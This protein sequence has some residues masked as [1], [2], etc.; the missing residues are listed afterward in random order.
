MAYAVPNSEAQ[1]F[2]NTG[3]SP[4]HENTLYFSSTSNKDSYFDGLTKYSVSSVTYQR[5]HRGF[6]RIELPV[7]SLIRCDYMRFKNNSF[8]N[9]WFY[10]FITQVNYINNNTTEI[11]YEL[12]PL[13][14]WMGAF[15]LK[16]CFV[17]RQHTHNDG[18][19][20]NICDEGL[21]CGEYVVESMK[22]TIDTS[23]LKI[24]TVYASAESGGKLVNNIFN[25]AYTYF[26]DT[27]EVDL[28]NQTLQ[29]LLGSNEIDNMV[30]MYMCPSE[31]A[32]DET[33]ITIVYAF[34]KPYTSVDG[35][36]PKNN[37]LFCYPFKYV[38]VDNME[39]GVQ[40]YMYEYFGTTPPTASS[41]MF[42]FR[43][44]GANNGN[45]DLVLYPVGYKVPNS[46]TDTTAIHHALGMHSFPLCSWSYD[47]YK[48]WLAQKN[49]YYELDTATTT[50]EAAIRGY[51]SGAQSGASTGAS[52][53]SQIGSTIG[54]AI[55]PG[56]GTAV[57]GI[58]GGLAG[59]A[60]G[61]LV[62]G[63]VEQARAK[64]QATDIAQYDSMIRNSVTPITPNKNIGTNSADVLTS[65][66][67]KTYQV[68]EMSITHNYAQMIDDYFTMYGYAVKQVLTPDMNV[69]PHWT[70]VKTIGCNVTGEFPASDARE[71]ED[72]FDNGVRFWHNISEMGNYSLDNSPS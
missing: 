72:I 29:D 56:V 52:T 57:G 16:Q 51:Y 34:D 59:G 28:L 1:F 43:V 64:K 31:F 49:A 53:G 18:I 67:A 32:Y 40:E 6:I 7:S 26:W 9:K 22:K 25:G 71:I 70:Y 66:G 17:E 21:P 69:R 50:G 3:L 8:E 15:S 46:S 23:S 33:P 19:G 41:G 48:A 60:I 11:R 63:E 58:A 5:E 42:N 55:L 12:D 54:S 62:G 24:G 20:N 39:G 14:T 61:G 44:S 4:S 45:L 2:I 65:L 37:K 38:E 13:I 35:Y 36:V 10:A 68:K 27:S 47:T 30:S